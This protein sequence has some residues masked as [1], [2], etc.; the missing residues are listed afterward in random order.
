MSASTDVSYFMGQGKVYLATRVAGGAINGGYL[1]V[2]DADACQLAA[3][4]KFDDVEES[5]S[6][7]RLVAAHIPIGLSYGV[8]L[9][10]LQWSMDNLV[11]A[12]Y[13]VSGGAQAAG[14]VSNETGT[15]WGQ[16]LYPLANP[17][18]SAVVAKL[19]GAATTLA[20]VTPLV[21]GTSAL[22]RGTRVAAVPVGETATTSPTVVAV[23]AA[24]GGVDHYEVT[25][26]GT[27]V[28]VPATSYTVA[29][30][31]GP[32]Q[33][34]NVGQTAL[35]ANTDYT[36]DAANGTL[37]FLAAS[38]KV[39]AGTLPD[40]YGNPITVNYSYASWN[41]KIEGVLTGIQEFAI[42]VIG[43]NTANG[44]APVHIDMWRY[45]MD[46]AKT[47]DF[48]MAKH[49]SLELSGMLLPDASKNGTTASQF[50]T[51]KKV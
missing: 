22:A 10:C 45:S 39:F 21:R 8:K 26:A 43:L 23:I 3:N 34:I 33:N 25:S 51:V 9:N 19:G 46:L 4:Q 42:K 48:I 49:G 17:G 13:G 20:S 18:V 7:N 5:Y 11:R 2:G 37:T 14:S 16:S 6:G 30:V 44:N 50:F 28:T 1:Y 32:T 15:G 41:G 47:L 35:T 31:T 36:L 40:T 12:T 24:D 38:T 29:G 27:G